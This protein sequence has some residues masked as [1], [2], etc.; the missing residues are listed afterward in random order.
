MGSSSLLHGSRPSR[1]A[2]PAAG[3]RPRT[4]RSVLMRGRMLSSAPET[5]GQPVAGK[6]GPQSAAFA[7]LGRS[8]AGRAAPREL[9]A[10]GLGCEPGASGRALLR[11]ALYLPQRLPD[12]AP[13]QLAARPGLLPEPL[14]PAA[15]RDPRGQPGALPFDRHPGSLDLRQVGRPLLPHRV[16]AGPA[17][18]RDLRRAEPLGALP[19]R[20]A[21]LL[22][23]GRAPGR[24]GH[25]RLS[26]PRAQLDPVQA[27][28]P[29]A[30]PHP[31]DF[32]L[33]AGSGVP[34]RSPALPQGRDRRG[35]RRGHQVH[36]RRRGHPDHRI[37]ARPRLARPAAVAL[38]RPGRAGLR[39]RCSSS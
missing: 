12:P 27:R 4:S 1:S 29:G 33:D 3:M 25:V 28:H 39:A 34:A 37:R 23:R 7:G 20:P 24:G 35:A 21:D 22:A 31:G 17:V 38:A 32:L 18:Q 16:P 13:G 36:G 15:D 8:S 6:T 5:H 11:R 30:A 14:L 10:A 26:P 2:R 19:H 9:R